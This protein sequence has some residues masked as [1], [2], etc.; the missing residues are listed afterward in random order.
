MP[1]PSFPLPVIIKIFLILVIVLF[2]PTFVVAEE[3]KIKIGPTTFM[4]TI[5]WATIGVKI[6]TS[7]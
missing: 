5:N 1:F 7:I 6:P 3:E 2:K 4:E